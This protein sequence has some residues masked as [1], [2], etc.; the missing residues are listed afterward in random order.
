MAHLP[1]WLE[2]SHFTD[3]H[4]G[5]PTDFIVSYLVKCCMPT[6][7]L[8]LQYVRSRLRFNN[9]ANVVV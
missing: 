7:R 4:V 3:R 2:I 8:I 6:E 1:V 9:L 5:V